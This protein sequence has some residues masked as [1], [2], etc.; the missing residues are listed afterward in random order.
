MKTIPF[1]DLR[2]LNQQ[3][4]KELYKKAKKVIDSGWYIQGE[5]CRS[6]EKNFAKYCETKYAVGVG[7]GY[8][9]LFLIFRAYKELGILQDGDAVLVPSH[10]YIATWLALTNN[11]LRPVSVDIKKKTFLID[12]KKLPSAI[13]PKT[14]AILVVHLYGQVCDMKPIY[15][16][17]K[18]YD[19]KIIEDAAQAHGALYKGKKVGSLG[20]AAAFSFYP[21]KT[22]GALG[23]GG[24]VTTNDSSLAKM[25]T[26]LKN[27]GSDTKYIHN[28][29]GYNSRL[30][31]IQAA[32]LNIK[33]SSLDEEIKKRKKIAKYYLKHIDNPC[34]ILPTILTDSS[35]HLFVIRTKYREKLQQFLE[36]NGIESGIHYPVAICKQQ[37]YKHEK[38]CKNSNKVSKEILSLPIYPTLT[39]KQLN[40]ICK[41]INNFKV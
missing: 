15:K 6:F 34:I 5:E 12:P 9:A 31:E 8:D 19:L 7:N 41:V 14:K 21:G 36:K 10:T 37:A 24:A 3:Y 17:A 35:W 30:D 33:L 38:C 26:A 23:D 20:D 13:T 11:N 40:Y 29:L 25:I 4:S 39:K 27:Y 16:L 28:Y 18:E 22:L 32:F 2:S 1:L